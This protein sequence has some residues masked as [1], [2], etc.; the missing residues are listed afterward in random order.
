MIKKIL[1]S[2]VLVMATYLVLSVQVEGKPLF[3][4]LYGW[5]APLTARVQAVASNLFGAGLQGSRAVGRKLFQNS[6]PAA[7]PSPAAA[8]GGPLRALAPTAPQDDVTPEDRQALDRL[9]Q[10]YAR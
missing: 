8:T 1:F 4:R 5:T 6:V 10:N 2:G 3:T 9:I 7:K